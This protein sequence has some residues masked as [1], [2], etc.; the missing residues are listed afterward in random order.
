M[1]QNKHKPWQKINILENWYIVGPN[2]RYEILYLVINIKITN[3][4]YNNIFY[5]YFV[6]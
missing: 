6:Q 4:L 1:V 3:L 2:F 5:E